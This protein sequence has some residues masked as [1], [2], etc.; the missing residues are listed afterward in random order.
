M[1]LS[2]SWHIWRVVHGGSWLSGVLVV[3]DISGLWFMVVP[4]MSSWWFLV[5]P[6]MSG[7]WFVVVPA[8]HI[9]LVVLSGSLHV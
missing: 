8:W 6:G 2:G 5:V 7:S 1:V 9:W 3:P 4:D